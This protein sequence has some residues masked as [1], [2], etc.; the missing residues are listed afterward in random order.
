MCKGLKSIKLPSSLTTIEEMAFKDCDSLSYINIPSKVKSIGR[1][2]FAGC[3]SLAR[4]DVDP[5]N[6]YFS[7]LDGILY[8]KNKSK[9]IFVPLST[10][11]IVVLPST[12]TEIGD[13]AFEGCVNLTN[14]TIPSSVISI[15]DNAFGGCSSLL[16]IDIPSSVTSLGSAFESCSL[17]DVVIDN[18]EENVTVGGYDFDGPKSIKFL[19]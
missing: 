5:K 10:N 3:T 7:S 11:G 15:G 2:V 13:G 17:L 14:I 4:I 16:G 19:K 1:D 12:V 18:S 6:S 9:V 8:D